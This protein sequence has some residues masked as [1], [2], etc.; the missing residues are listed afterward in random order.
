MALSDALE[1]GGGWRAP[2]SPA[3]RQRA[4]KRAWRNSRK[5]RALRVIFPLAGL[6]VLGGL[7][8]FVNLGLPGDIDLN[9]A[10]L[11]VTR[12]SIIMDNPHL[13]GFDG[14]RREYS[15][16]ADRAIQ[17]LN[18]PGEVRL[19]RIEARVSNAGEGT[20]K[21]VAE[22]GDYNHQKRTARLLGGVS[23]DSAEGYRLRMTDAHLD[24]ETGSIVSDGSVAITY[25]DSQI[26]GS[27]LSVSEHGNVIV[28]DG[29]V[30]TTLMPPKRPAASETD[31]K[32]VDAD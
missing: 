18:A 9:A 24:F 30:R 25:A 8:A 27:R 20:S 5:V 23:V 6:L 16:T 22:A 29:S 10:K 28:I 17:L 21:V 7:A 31:A 3:E 15:L 13:T 12:N 32:P 2:L 14:D 26:T 4:F 1:G 19:E 11:S